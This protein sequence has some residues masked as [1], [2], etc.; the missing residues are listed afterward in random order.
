MPSKVTRQPRVLLPTKDTQELRCYLFFL[1]IAAPAIAGASDVDFWLTHIPQA[2]HFDRAVWH[3]VV[4][5]GAAYE[6][7]LGNRGNVGLGC[8]SATFVPQQVNAA[9]KHLLHAP[10]SPNPQAGW[11]ALTASI[12]FTHLCSIQGFYTQSTIHLAAAKKLLAEFTE[13]DTEVKNGVAFIRSTDNP[14][15]YDTAFS[16]VSNLEVNSQAIQGGSANAV[17]KLLDKANSSWRYYTAPTQPVS[18]RICHHGRCVPSR[19]TPLHMTRAAEAFDSL[20]KAL[21]M[22]SH[23]CA[24]NVERLALEADRGL[25]ETVIGNQ[26]PHAR[27]FYELSKALAIFSADTAS[28]CRCILPDCSR[29]PN[30]ASAERERQQKMAI[31]SLALCQLS[32]YTLLIRKPHSSFLSAPYLSRLGEGES[33]AEPLL[34][35][36]VSRALGLAESIMQNGPLGRSTG[37]DGFVPLVPTTLP[38]F[39]MA[40]TPGVDAALRQ[41]VVAILR[42]YPRCGHQWDSRLA[43]AV[44]EA[45]MAKE[46]EL[47]TRIAH[48]LERKGRELSEGE[49]TLETRKRELEK[50]LRTLPVTA[51]KVYKIGETFTR[52][53]SSSAIVRSWAAS[54]GKGFE[55]DLY[56]TQPSARRGA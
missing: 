7:Y 13:T 12:L 31:D 41:R 35:E 29:G 2:C 24:V 51:D 47:S 17:P 33:A 27:A 36:H 14:V 4:S 28:R 5:I 20:L 44:V 34:K 50:G 48:D 43:A 8:P 46:R 16:L 40:H 23:D 21:I 49:Y 54:Q 53:C 11:R 39:T 9:L 42:K 22:L 1:E 52:A 10:S 3:A 18:S 15:S 37:V 19:A 45:G 25:F 32:C 56:P 6:G 26:E 30:L 38:L 55:Q